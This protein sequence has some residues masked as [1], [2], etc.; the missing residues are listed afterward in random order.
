MRNV[1]LAVQ[2][3]G[4]LAALTSLPVWGEET[5]FEIAAVAGN[6]GILD[7]MTDIQQ[8]DLL[9]I[10]AGLAAQDDFRIIKKIIRDAS[11]EYIAFCSWEEDFELAREGRRLG[12]KEYFAFPFEP[13]SFLQV[14]DKIKA[15]IRTSKV[16]TTK[17]VRETVYYFEKQDPDL[18]GYLEQ[19]VEKPFFSQIL[20]LSIKEVFKNNDWMDL[21]FDEEFFYSEKTLDKRRQK[22]HFTL[23][24]ESVRRLYPHHNDSL[25]DVI[26]YILYNPESDLRQKT[27]SEEL[28]L[29][30]SYLSTVFT[31]QTGLR[32]VDYITYVKLAR[33][34]WLLKNTDMRISEIAERMDYKD[35]AYFSRLF[36]KHFNTTP[37]EYRIPDNYHFII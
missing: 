35:I 34:A 32:F 17:F 15:G 7:K 29:N 30:Q 11:C 27:L 4:M 22:E 8:F 24:F 33:A 3:S 1:I 20:D 13:Q 31:A 5:G 19:F 36:K 10:E 18:Y 6:A 21:Y 25:K 14:F 37:S 16:N 2:S 26:L 9:I 12:V 23:L 28:H